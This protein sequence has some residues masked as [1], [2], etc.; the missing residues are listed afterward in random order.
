MKNGI[1]TIQY[2]AS[3]R[4][5]AYRFEGVAQSFPN[6]FHAHYA[7]GLVE[8]GRHV[9]SCKNQT[10]VLGPGSVVAFNPGD[11]HACIQDEGGAFDYRGLNIEAEALRAW[12]PDGMGAKGPLRFS[13][14]VTDDA[15]TACHLYALH[16]MILNGAPD[17]QKEERLFLLLA[18]LGRSCG[19]AVAG[20]APGETPGDIS[21]DTLANTTGDT[22]EDVPEDTHG[23]TPGGAPEDAPNHRQE[24]GAV[25]AFL[26]AHCAEHIGLDM[27]CRHAGL[28]RST[29]LRAFIRAKGVTPYRYLE[30]VR[31]EQARALLRGGVPP[32]EAALR[33]GFSDQSHFT[34][35]FSSV[36]G[37]TPGAYRDTFLERARVGAGAGA[38]EKP[39]AAQKETQ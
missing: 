17:L 24:V 23:G 4:I 15:E 18:A 8:R 7:L 1:R 12:A 20:D 25:C 19:Q 28:S 26:R 13:Q 35:Y 5:E 29:L 2:D 6:H 33:T 11:S 10:Y 39:A 36:T 38:G 21:D 9:L 34:N 27:L 16:E 30:N 37:L 32:L 14:N 31:V 22:P 3:L